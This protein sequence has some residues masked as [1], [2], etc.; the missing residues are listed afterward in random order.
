MKAT[1]RTTVL[2]S[3]LLLALATMAQDNAAPAAP[4]TP[5]TAVGQKPGTV[6]RT[7]APSATPRVNDGFHGINIGMLI[8]R[9]NLTP[10]QT[11]K[12]KDLNTDYYKMHRDI[13]ADMPLEER[14]AKVTSMMAER[15]AKV[16]AVLTPDQQKQY[17][18]ANAEMEARRKALANGTQL[19][20]AAA[21][22]KEVKP[23]LKK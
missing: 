12:L 3:G 13:P 2:T 16:L 8:K 23:E 4:N 7:T 9:A 15:E 20:P 14:K 17:A 5:P 19:S 21:P 1:F 11:Q 18:E 6:A 10:E 22:S